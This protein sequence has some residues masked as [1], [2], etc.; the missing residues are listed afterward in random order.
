MEEEQSSIGVR[1]P[2]GT[3]TEVGRLA[4]KLGLTAFGGPAAHIAM[5]RREVVDD[6]KWID[7]KTF[8]LFLGLT[9]LIP[10]PNST[11]MVLLT[12]RTRAG[13]R[14]LLIAGAGFISPAFLITLT[15][16]A[17][18]VRY[19]TRAGAEW[20]LYGVKPVIVVIVFHALYVLAQ[21][22]VRK[23]IA[24]IVAVGAAVGYLAGI[25]ELLLLIVGGLM[26]LASNS[27]SPRLKDL[28]RTSF[29]LAPIKFGVLTLAA[30]TADGVSYSAGRLFWSF[31]KIGAVLYGSG[32]VLIAFL[33][34][35]FVVNLGWI[36]EHNCSMR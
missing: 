11:E 17:L 16:A 29:S 33:R 19:G 32:Y 28:H 3:S 7:D 5:L 18:Y 25:N 14:G 24:A 34:S 10:G 36:T 27:L 23:P 9:N 22:Q 13:I 12:G 21:I 8:S 2:T 6:R 35:E 15:F 1:E 4:L 20:L 31:L 26:L 30:S